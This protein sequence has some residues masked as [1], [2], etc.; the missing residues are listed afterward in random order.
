MCFTTKRAGGA[1]HGKHVVG[2][3]RFAQQL[4]LF[5]A[6]CFGGE[7]GIGVECE[8]TRMLPRKRHGISSL[9]EMGCTAPPGVRRL[10]GGENPREG[11][12]Q[13]ICRYPLQIFYDRG[14]HI[15]TPAAVQYA[16][17]CVLTPHDI[18]FHENVV[19]R[20]LSTSAKIV[21]Y[22]SSRNRKRG[23]NFGTDMMNIDECLRMAHPMMER[24][25]LCVKSRRCYGVLRSSSPSEQNVEDCTVGDVMFVIQNDLAAMY[26][27]YGT[28]ALV[29]TFRNH[30]VCL[31]MCARLTLGRHFDSSREEAVYLLYDSSREFL[32]GFHSPQDLLK[33]LT[34]RCTDPGNKHTVC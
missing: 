12:S 32:L 10:V 30:T 3:Q 19:D 16:L 34:G 18:P 31:V 26:N 14:S 27:S 33:E 1:L 4:S 13:N 6:K 11:V 17:Q 23:V 29:L 7:L 9:D 24:K 15:C 8:G 2:F 21:A 20:I 25:G 5:L 22:N 28:A